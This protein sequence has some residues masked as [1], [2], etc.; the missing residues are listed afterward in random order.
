MSD[1]AA[2]ALAL[3]VRRWLLESRVATFA[4]L[5]VDAR[6]AGHPFCSI[7]PYALDARGRPLVQIASIAAHTKNVQADP[8]ASLFVH[9][10]S[11]N[12]QVDPQAGWRITLVGRMAR[13]PEAENAEALARLVEHVP[14]ALE[15]EAT[16][17]FSLW[18]LDI[19]HVRCI[20]GFGRIAWVD[21]A[22]V[23]RDPLGAGLAEAA[24]GAVA[25]MNADHADSMREMCKGLAGFTP[26]RAEAVAIDRT[27]MLVRCHEP[28]RLVHFSFGKEIDAAGLRGAVVD[29]VRRARAVTA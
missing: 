8:R 4:T 27:G 28:D 5:S 2:L 29:I 16:H 14:R 23:M 11:S 7:V 18:R 1:A 13:V 24:P 15:Y 3:D 10:G 19:E 26:T 9:E 20:A 12:A 22:S 17:D 6:C 21:A 25:H